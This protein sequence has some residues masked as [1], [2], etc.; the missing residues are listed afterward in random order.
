MALSKKAFQ[1]RVSKVKQSV[2][3]KQVIESTGAQPVYSHAAKGEYI[4]H[5]PYRQDNDPSLKINVHEQ[6]FYDF[7]L[8]GSNGDVIELVRRIFGKGDI[9]AMPFFKAI[10]WLERF[11]GTSVAPKAFQPTQQSK[12]KLVQASYEGDRFT[13]VR[14]TPVSAKTHPTNLDYILNTRKISLPVASRHLYVITYKDRT[15]P[16][17]DPLRGQRYGIGGP[18]D[19]GG[20]EV[21]APSRNSNFKTSLGPKGITTYAGDDPE[22]TTGDIF[23][24][25]MDFMTSLDL[26][27]I[28][29]PSSPTII[30]N[31]GRFAATAVEAIKTQPELQRITSWRIWQQ[32]DQQGEETTQII[33]T[34]LLDHCAAGTVNH[35]WESYNDLNKWW[36]DAPSQEIYKVKSLFTGK[37][38]P[39]KFYDGS[40]TG[41]LRRAHESKL[42][43]K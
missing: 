20:W 19:L 29:Q 37:E 26:R 1:E 12:S 22:A 11:S 10:E 30:L 42:R 36:T 24:G 21:R 28:V 4:Y 7:G 16:I 5:A 31:S 40:M 25:R 3:I 6:R 9:D 33:C 23:E 38:Q 15:A 39:V 8:E 27:G 43:P 35:Y 17:D 13:F 34:G 41:E 32:N 18:N 2:D 14:A